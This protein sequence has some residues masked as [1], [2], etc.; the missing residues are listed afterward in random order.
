MPPALSLDTSARGVQPETLGGH[1]LRC[2]D[3][4]LDDSMAT[5]FSQ[6]LDRLSAPKLNPAS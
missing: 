5:G 1:S 3:G 2:R 4:C 6:L